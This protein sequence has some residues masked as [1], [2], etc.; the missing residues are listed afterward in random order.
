M[1]VDLAQK[2]QNFT[3]RGAK[4]RLFLALYLVVTKKVPTT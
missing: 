1:A 3:N 4:W 2:A